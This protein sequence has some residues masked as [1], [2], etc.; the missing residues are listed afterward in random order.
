MGDYGFSPFVEN[1]IF[2]GDEAVGSVFRAIKQQGK[3][4]TWLNHIKEVRES[5]TVIKIVLATSLSSVFYDLTM[6]NC[7]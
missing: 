3:R 5:S 7:N 6:I 2:D 4:E 1:L